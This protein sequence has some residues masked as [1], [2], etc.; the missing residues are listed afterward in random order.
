[1]KFQNGLQTEVKLVME[2]VAIYNLGEMVK[3]DVAEELVE[4]GVEFVAQ[5]TVE[6]L[7]DR[8]CYYCFR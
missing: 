5:S 6:E 2:E 8:G 3:E 1:M 4:V 7:L